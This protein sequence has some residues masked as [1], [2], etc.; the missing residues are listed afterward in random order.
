MSLPQTAR[1]FAL[2]GGSRL[3]VAVLGLV[4]LGAMAG[5]GGKSDPIPVG[6]PVTTSGEDTDVDTADTGSTVDTGDSGETDS[7]PDSDFWYTASLAGGNPGD[8]AQ[9][10][11]GDDVL[12]ESGSARLNESEGEFSLQFNYTGTVDGLPYQA[13]CTVPFNFSG[14]LP[15]TT[16][17]ASSDGKAVGCPSIEL[18]T[19]SYSLNTDG[20]TLVNVND[21]TVVSGTFSLVVQSSAGHSLQANGEFFVRMCDTFWDGAPCTY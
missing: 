1:A 4:V 15:A 19:T 8:E 21:G 20:L 14:G 5:C 11:D 6:T 9:F 7:T 17:E 10:F 13:Q 12:I 18:G 2:R 3:G 16:A